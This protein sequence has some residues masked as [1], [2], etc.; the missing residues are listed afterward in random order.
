MNADTMF[1]TKPSKYLKAAD[2]G[3]RY[4][5]VVMDRVQIETL[6][7]G[8]KA[9]QKLVLYFQ[10]KEKG[11]ALNKTNKNAIVSIA[12]SAET[13][14]WRGK[15]IVI[16]PAMTEM[17]GEP[18]ECIRIARPPANTAQPK[19]APP[20]HPYPAPYSPPVTITEPQGDMTPIT[21][22]DVPF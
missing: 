22:D 8:A 15:P 3:G 21:D 13:D 19:P 12:G 5:V 6:G 11:L 16:H 10:G 4:L 1:P 17:N 20:A 18:V 7:Q 9:E 2:L 14:V